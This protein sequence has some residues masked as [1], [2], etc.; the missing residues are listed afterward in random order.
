MS[1][2]EHDLSWFGDLSAEERSW[3]GQIVQAGVRGF[4]DWYRAYHAV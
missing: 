3:V 1:H 2:M 4:V